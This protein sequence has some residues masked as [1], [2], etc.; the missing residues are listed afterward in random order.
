MGVVCLSQ[1]TDLDWSN[2]VRPEPEGEPLRRAPRV[3]SPV[4]APRAPPHSVPA[5]NSVLPTSEA[6]L[7]SSRLPLVPRTAGDMMIRPQVLAGY[8]QVYR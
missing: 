5:A 6:L 8:C 4:R 2:C 7:Y 1:T 3:H